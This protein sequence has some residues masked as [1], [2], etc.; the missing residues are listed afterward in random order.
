MGNATDVYLPHLSHFIP[1]E[2]PD[3]VAK[4]LIQAVEA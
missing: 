4:H 1:M 2:D 3:L